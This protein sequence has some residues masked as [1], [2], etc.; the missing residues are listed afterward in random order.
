MRK[1]VTARAGQ[2]LMDVA[3]QW[4]GNADMAM[5]LAT[6]NGVEETTVFSGGE[7]LAVPPLYEAAGRKMAAAGVEPVTGVDLPA[8]DGELRIGVGHWA[9]GEFVVG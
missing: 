8:D 5:E 9:V 2:S 3:V 7:V 1:T 6:L 4:C